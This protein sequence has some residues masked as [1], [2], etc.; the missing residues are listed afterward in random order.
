MF[1]R[2]EKSIEEQEVASQFSNATSQL[3]NSSCDFFLSFLNLLES[4]EKRKL[5]NTENFPSTQTSQEVIEMK[6]EKNPASS[7]DKERKDLVS[8]LSRLSIDNNV[9]EG[10]TDLPQVFQV[11]IYIFHNVYPRALS[12]FARNLTSSVNT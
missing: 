6:K 1:S 2:N 8:K 7:T 12:I 10:S 5:C 3:I 4:L 11:Y 9:F